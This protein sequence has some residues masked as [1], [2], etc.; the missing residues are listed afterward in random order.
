MRPCHSSFKVI[1]HS[2]TVL[3]RLTLV[4]V[5]NRLQNF[6]YSLPL[7]VKIFWKFKWDHVWDIFFE[8]DLQMSE[9]AR[10]INKAGELK[11][12]RE[13]SHLL[14]KSVKNLNCETHTTTK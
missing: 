12:R 1:C 6:A 7:E 8:I 2:T 10:K 5:G 4:L 11:K 9:L 3:G 13:D 14:L